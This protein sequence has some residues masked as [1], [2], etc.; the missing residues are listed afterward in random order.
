[1][2]QQILTSQCFLFFHF[3]SYL[4]F[5]WSVLFDDG[6]VIDLN[7]HELYEC[8]CTMNDNKATGKSTR[9]IAA[10]VSAATTAAVVTPGRDNKKKPP[11][12]KKDTSN[13]KKS[14]Q[15]I[16]AKK[17]LCA[18]PG[19]SE[20]EV[21]FALEE[22]GHPYGLQSVMHAIQ[23]AR[24]DDLDWIEPAT[25]RFVPQVGMRVRKM[26][27]GKMMRGKAIT[28]S[29]KTSLKYIFVFFAP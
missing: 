1:M 14:D 11:S 23:K 5:S 2:I 9:R 8:C 25:S 15:Y 29:I 22:V 4:S 16:A 6:D 10:G 24:N 20:K 28:I 21:E 27:D 7:R 13:K 18:L 26:F 12:K 17:A 3:V 19:N